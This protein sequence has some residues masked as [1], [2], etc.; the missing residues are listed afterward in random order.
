MSALRSPQ[1]FLLY[2][3]AALVLHSDRTGAAVM[4]PASQICWDM[5][6]AT[7][8]E[9][10]AERC[11]RRGYP[12]DCPGVAIDWEHRVVSPDEADTYAAR[13]RQDARSL[14]NW[15]G[16]WTEGQIQIAGCALAKF[17]DTR[18]KDWILQHT[19]LN[20]YTAD[21]SNPVPN[22]PLTAYNSVLRFRG[23]F[24]T[25]KTTEARRE[26]LLAFE[27][28]RAFW[29]VVTE[30]GTN[31]TGQWWFT[32]HQS[33]TSI[34]FEMKAAKFNGENLGG[35]GDNDPMAMM[36]YVF[37]AEALQLPKPQ[38]PEQQREWED[39]ISEFENHVGQ[40]F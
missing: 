25:N 35:L 27:G 14:A 29:S 19:Q 24:F 9:Q 33:H 1:K 40:V 36:A 21:D 5:D 6:A 37:R 12:D 38:D 2:C 3:I 31:A 4:D 23:V 10:S 28:G 15:A 20:R 18:F 22:N 8:L 11:R 17:Q 32:Y 13:Q 30:N 39:V 34:I 26:N 16:E 7:R